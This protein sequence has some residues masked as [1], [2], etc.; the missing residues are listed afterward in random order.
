MRAVPLA[1]AIACCA[2][3]AHAQQ[4]PADW[5]RSRFPDLQRVDMRTVLQEGRA[6]GFAGSPAETL[7]FTR[8]VPPRRGTDRRA[9]PWPRRGDREGPVV[10][11]PGLA[12]FATE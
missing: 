6:A 3:S 11:A 1:L 7:A 10:A 2:L 8:T 4:S 12:V 9:M 5:I